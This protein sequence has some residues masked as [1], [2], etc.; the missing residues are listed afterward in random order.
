MHEEALMRDLR[1][2]VEELSRGAGGAPILRA[3]VVLGPLAHVDEPRLRQL[4][5]RAMAGGPAERA[6][7][8]VELLSS[9][10]DPRAASLVLRTV[11]FGSAAVRPS[12][13]SSVRGG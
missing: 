3:S 6:V 2:K 7:L 1:R 11:T 9:P 13:T 8:E 12:P 5:A 4:W 10:T